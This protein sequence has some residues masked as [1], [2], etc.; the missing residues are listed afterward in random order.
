MSEMMAMI[1]IKGRGKHP[2]KIADG[3]IDSKLKAEDQVYHLVLLQQKLDILDVNRNCN[4][5]DFDMDDIIAS[6]RFIDDLE[7]KI[8][9]IKL[10]K[11]EN[12]DIIYIAWDLKEL[13]SLKQAKE[14]YIESLT[15]L[16]PG[17]FDNL[18]RVED[19]TTMCIA[20]YKTLGEAKYR[21]EEIMINYYRIINS[22]RLKK[23]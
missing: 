9:R 3:L 20:D 17:H 14:K 5:A 4:K 19:A 16:H 22:F 1:N 15:I 7:N 11:I 13:M 21:V 6:Y 10:E 2:V 23:Y 18:Y 12:D 8:T